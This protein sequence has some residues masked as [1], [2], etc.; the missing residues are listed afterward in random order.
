MRSA[1][2]ATVQAP[3][4]SGIIKPA[5]GRRTKEFASTICCSPRRP[6]TGSPRAA[7]TSTFAAGTSR[8]TTF[9]SG[10]IW[11]WRGHIGRSGPL[12][13]F[14]AQGRARGI[15]S[16]S[17]P[18]LEETVQNAP[19]QLV[20]DAHADDVIV[21]AHMLIARKDRT[22]SRIEVG[23]VLQ[24]DIE[25]FHLGRPVRRELHLDAAAHGPTPMPVLV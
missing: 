13:G 21:H 24:P 6:R 3:T 20:I 11:R 10:S 15:R 22:G 1:R 4:H 8:P 12:P 16:A 17:A 25:I 7:S 19:G 23:L 14:R 5:P 9:Q 2:P 18:G